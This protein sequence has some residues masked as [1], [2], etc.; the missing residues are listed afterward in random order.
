MPTSSWAKVVRSFLEN[1]KARAAGRASL[2]RPDEPIPAFWAGMAELGWLGL[3]VPE[4]HGGSGFGL[5][6]LFVVVEELGH[7]IAPGPFLPTVLVSST[8]AH[9]DDDELSSRWLPGLVDGSLT[10]AARTRQRCG[11]SG[12]RAT[13]G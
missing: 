5:S 13:Q 12:G 8:L 9:F 1:E 11:T 3:H 7:A 10:G 2:D 4:A 6:E